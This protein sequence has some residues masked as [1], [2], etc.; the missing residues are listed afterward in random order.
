MP[1]TKKDYH[2]V[3]QQRLP[4]SKDLRTTPKLNASA[5]FKAKFDS[6]LAFK[7]RQHRKTKLEK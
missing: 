1:T 4:F 7:L 3:N 2:N 6:G 5:V